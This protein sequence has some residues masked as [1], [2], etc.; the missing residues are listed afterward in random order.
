[1]H[2]R[3]RCVEPLEQ[4]SQT[5]VS[6]A[7]GCWEAN[8]GSRKNISL[9]IQCSDIGSLRVHLTTEKEGGIVLLQAVAQTIVLP[10]SIPLSPPLLLLTHSKSFSF[11]P[12][13]LRFVWL[14]H[15]VITGLCHHIPAG[16]HS[17]SLHRTLFKMRVYSCNNKIRR[18]LKNKKKVGTEEKEKKKIF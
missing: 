10:P 5:L 17:I 13:E 3:G 14:L 9:V 4:Q 15:S 6:C 7:S 12:G 11:F 16:S 18:N 8:P 2:T 1:M